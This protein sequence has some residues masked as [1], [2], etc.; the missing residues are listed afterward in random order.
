MCVREREISWRDRRERFF[1]YKATSANSQEL[2]LQWFVGR[3]LYIAY[4]LTRRFQWQQNILRPEAVADIPTTVV[5]SS[6][7]HIVP[8]HSVRRFLVSWERRR[9][10]SRR[11]S[12]AQ[13]LG[14]A[15][16]LRVVWLQGCGHAGFLLSRPACNKVLKAVLS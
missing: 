14:S 15:P 7:D 4:T 9:R 5:L 11:D 2:M 6:E 13:K 1:F 3:E 10:Q 16:Q 12:G 8:S